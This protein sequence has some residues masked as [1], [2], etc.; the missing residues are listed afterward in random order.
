M[1]PAAPILVL[2]RRAEP[3]VIAGLLG[4]PFPDM[5][6][7][8]VDLER[9]RVAVGGELQADAE[10]VLIE[11]GSRQDA[12]WGGNDFP[13]VGEG[14]CIEYTSLINIRPSAGNPSM[15]VVSAGVRSR[16]REIVFEIVGR[17][18]SLP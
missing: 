17:G 7:F 15:T 3:S 5:I 14:E 18:E 10:A 2:T 4:R 13:G 6:K 11:A 16:M 9:R 12:L 8:V 1:A